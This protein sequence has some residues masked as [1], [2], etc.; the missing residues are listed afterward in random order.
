MKTIYP[1]E[2]LH[3]LE[4][5]SKVYWDD[6]EEYVLTSFSYIKEPRFREKFI[7]HFAH[8]DGTSSSTFMYNPSA[9][10]MTLVSN[11]VFIKDTSEGTDLRIAMYKI[12]PYLGD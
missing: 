8:G 4:N 11:V 5:A 6:N 2:L 1:D 12:I 9:M 7:L 10:E 3:L